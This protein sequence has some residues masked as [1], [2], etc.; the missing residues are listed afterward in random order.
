LGQMVLKPLP[1]SNQYEDF[2]VLN[3]SNCIPPP[4]VELYAHRQTDNRTDDRPTLQNLEEILINY[5]VFPYEIYEHI[6]NHRSTVIEICGQ[7]YWLEF[8]CFLIGM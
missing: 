5:L 7:N 4:T 6:H 1:I 8:F 3:F 2:D